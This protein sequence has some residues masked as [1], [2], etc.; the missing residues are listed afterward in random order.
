M[1]GLS[2]LRSIQARCASAL[3]PFPAVEVEANLA[4]PTMRGDARGVITPW[5]SGVTCCTASR[6]AMVARQQI[7]LMR[8]RTQM[9]RIHAVSHLANVVDFVAVRD[10]ADHIDIHQAVNT[11]VLPL[12]G[13]GAPSR[14]PV[15]VGLSATHPQPASI[16]NL[17]LV[18]YSSREDHV[19]QP[20][21][22][23]GVM[24]H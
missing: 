8:D 22:Y 2:D 15:A 11:G 5:V 4:S 6:S 1:K 23:Q 10:R 20:N 9:V 18:H 16:G 14:I 17:D 12:P 24:G 3:P 19:S 13:R 7:L 21:I